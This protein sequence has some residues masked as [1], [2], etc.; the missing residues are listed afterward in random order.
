VRRY[1][2]RPG[3]AQ[4]HHRRLLEGEF[5]QSTKA[6]T[7]YFNPHS[8]RNTLV[9]LGQ[10]LRQSPEKFKARGV[11]CLGHDKVLPTSL[12]DGQVESSRQGKVIRRLATPPVAVQ[13]VVSELAAA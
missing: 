9:R 7:P 12:S 2:H 6:G 1:A 13:A 4:H 10:S 8:F 3:R 5:L 11:K